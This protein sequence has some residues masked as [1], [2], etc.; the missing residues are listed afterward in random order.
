MVQLTVEQHCLEHGCNFGL[1]ESVARSQAA[2][3]KGLLQNRQLLLALLSLYPLLEFLMSSIKKGFIRALVQ[4]PTLNTGQYANNIWAGFRAERV[5]TLCN[6]LRRIAR[7]PIRFQQCISKMTPA[8]VQELKEL[9]DKVQLPP[10][11]SSST[12]GHSSTA[13]SGSGSTAGR[14]S[15]STACGSDSAAATG[16]GSRQ[17]KKEDSIVTVD[18]DGFPKMLAAGEDAEEQDEEDEE[19]VGSDGWPKML[20]A[21]DDA[22][23]QEDQEE[24]EEDE[25]EE[26]RG[27]AL[28]L[29]RPAAACGTHKAK[30]AKKEKNDKKEEELPKQLEPAA[31][32]VIKITYAK[33]QTYFHWQGD[34]MTS[35][36]ARQAKGHSSGQ[37]HA[38]LCL[39]VA[40]H[41]AKSSSPSKQVALDIRQHVLQETG[42]L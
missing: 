31:G 8:E 18:S 17:L 29:K 28:C 33:E 7:E 1:Y 5:L 41:F 14:V 24:E 36:S 23:D 6:H 3:G 19:E 26:K 37:S 30:K 34:F 2:V 21:G 25:K 42:E 39:C 10:G 32:G 9:M 40:K 4:R 20:A 27:A 13:A 12:Q 35:V 11:V 16:S 22:E 15:G 38:Q